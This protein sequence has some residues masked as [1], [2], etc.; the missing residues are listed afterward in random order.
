[1][2]KK[3][4]VSLLNKMLKG[5][6]PKDRFN[7]NNFREHY[8]HCVIGELKLQRPEILEEGDFVRSLKLLGFSAQDAE[9]CNGG[10]GD[11]KSFTHTKALKMIRNAIKRVQGDK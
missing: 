11:N 8:P 3:Q 10:V 7:R 4:I 2:N 6:T 9:L 5:L 1:M